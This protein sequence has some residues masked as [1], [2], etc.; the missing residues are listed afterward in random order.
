VCVCV[1]VCVCVLG[2]CCGIL[3][4]LARR[5]NTDDKGW[6]ARGEPLYR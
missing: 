1:C 4:A 6:D 5:V 3:G 2:V